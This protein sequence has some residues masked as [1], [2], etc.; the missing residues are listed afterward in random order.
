[1]RDVQGPASCKL[2]FAF[3]NDMFAGKVHKDGLA[4]IG[5]SL[6]VCWCA[7]SHRK[8]SELGVGRSDGGRK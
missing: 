2:V 6:G 1:M 8:Q 3:P 7:A 4:G 5:E